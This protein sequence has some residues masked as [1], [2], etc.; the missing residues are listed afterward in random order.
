MHSIC[1][2]QRVKDEKKTSDC[3]VQKNELVQLIAVMEV[4]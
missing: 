1:F 3:I 2:P 4:K